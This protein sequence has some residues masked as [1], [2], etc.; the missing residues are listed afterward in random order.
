M[1]YK[2]GQEVDIVK[3][4][5]NFKGNIDSGEAPIKGE[6]KHIAKTGKIMVLIKKWNYWL[7]PED[8]KPCGNLNQSKV[9]TENSDFKVL[10][11]DFN[12]STSNWKKNGN[13]I[14]VDEFIKFMSPEAYKKFTEEGDA[15]IRK[16]FP[17]SQEEKDALDKMSKELIE[18]FGGR[19]PLFATGSL[20]KH[21]DTGKKYIIQTHLKEYD[22]DNKLLGIYYFAI[23]EGQ[24][25]NKPEIFNEELLT[26]APSTRKFKALPRIIE[27]YQTDREF[28][29]PTLEGDMKASVG[30]YVVIGVKGEKYAV[31]EDIF[32]ICYEEI[33][34]MPTPNKK[35]KVNDA[36]VL[37]GNRESDM[38]VEDMNVFDN[39]TGWAFKLHSGRIKG[40]RELMGFKEYS[41]KRTLQ[42]CSPY[43]KSVF[44]EGQIVNLPD[45][46]KNAQGLVEH[47]IFRDYGW[48]YNVKIFDELNNKFDNKDFSE[49]ILIQ[50][51]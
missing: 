16:R 4:P 19:Q 37:L 25:D 1:N 8:I 17:I 10:I 15:E 34:D 39:A 30:D 49:N 22:K 38:I 29:I 50:F 11:D 41:E 13:A 12:Q 24:A 42:P 3:L 36:V 45:G 40:E 31:K 21:K 26:D 44:S 51:T 23:A 27:A 6:I 28:I 43:P 33:I 46:E 48:E 35:F 7:N 2:V 32:K 47:K 18:K 5:E 9:L 20:I 14:S